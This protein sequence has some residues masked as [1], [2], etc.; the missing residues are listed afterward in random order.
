MV[1]QYKNAVVNCILFSLFKVQQLVILM[2]RLNQM[3]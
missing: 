2:A 3:M 1:T